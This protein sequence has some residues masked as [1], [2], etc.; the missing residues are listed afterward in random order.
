MDLI[1]LFAHHCYQH[2]HDKI[3]DKL[4]HGSLPSTTSCPASISCSSSNDAR[5]GGF[6][7][8]PWFCDK[9]R[10]LT[11]GESSSDVSLNE[12]REANA[13]VGDQ[14]Y[15]DGTEVFQDGNGAPVENASP[16]GYH[17]GWFGILF[18]NI[19]QMVG[20]GV[21]STP[22]SILNNLDSVGLSLLYWVIG[23]IIAATSLAVYLE[24]AALFPNRSGSQVVYLEQAFPKPLLFF[25]TAYAF[26]TVVFS[27]SSSNAIVLSRYIFRAAGYTATEWQNKS[28]AIGANSVLYVICLLSTKWSMRI[29]N[30]IT[31]VKIGILLFI[32]ITGF[33][34]LGGGTRVEDP[35]ANFRNSFEGVTS[36]GNAIV[37]AL[38][39]INFAYQGYAN[40]FN[41]VAEVK[42]PFKTLRIAAPVSVLLV[43]ILYILTNVAYFAAVLKESIASSGELT[44]ALF[45]E[46]VFGRAGRA[47]P[48]LVTVSAAGNILAVIIGT[49]RSIREC[50][51]QGVVPWPHIWASTRPFGTPFAPILLKWFLT[52]MI[53]LV[54]PF[55]DAFNFLVDLRSYSDNIFLFLM[56][57]GIYFIRYRRKNLGLPQ[58][59]FR[60][61]HSAT[62]FSILVTLFLLV[63]PW[64]PPEGGATGGDVSFWYATYCVVGIGLMLAC[65]AYYFGWVWV[66][67]K[68]RNYSIRTETLVNGRDGSVTHR[69]RRVLNEDVGKWDETHDDAGNLLVAEG[70]EL[71]EKSE[72]REQGG[73]VKRVHVKGSRPL[74]V[75]DVGKQG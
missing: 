51:R 29:M 67:P 60:V 10:Y 72:H 68:L 61:W 14:I 1:R 73:L 4:R 45:F 42:R 47:L 64:Y 38:V 40:D 33:V 28:L 13:T 2:K 48:A 75:D 71:L 21:F 62:I 49:S 16:L 8:I 53:I 37:N 66:L 58:A 20:T 41:V 34:V 30:F 52:T 65:A 43:S 46:A 5:L 18:L 44:A 7:A 69:M 27:F 32:V 55:G 56:T 17:V 74:S 26:F 36:N 57:A 15:V 35:G 22:S 63:M 3:S 19:S 11:W 70:E 59:E 9:K 50:G 25:P 31:A 23:A 12:V 54:L 39:K 24:Y 6:T